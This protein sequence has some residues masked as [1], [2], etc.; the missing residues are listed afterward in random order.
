MIFTLKFSKY[1]ECV[2][3]K[4]IASPQNKVEFVT[5][6]KLYMINAPTRIKYLGE[7]KLDRETKPQYNM[8]IVQ[9]KPK[10]AI[11]YCTVGFEGYTQYRLHSQT[12]SLKFFEKTVVVVVHRYKREKRREIFGLESSSLPSS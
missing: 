10:A 6:F 2:H 3:S 5:K 11:A 4:L 9:A 7:V 8:L 1:L 12:S